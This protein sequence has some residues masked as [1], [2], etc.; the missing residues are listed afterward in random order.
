MTTTIRD[1]VSDAIGRIGVL[2]NGQ[3]MPN[4]MAQKTLRAL[5]QMMS[6]WQSRGLNYQHST[7]TLDDDWALG[8]ELEGD[9][10]ALLALRMTDDYAP[11]AAT[12]L[13]RRDARVGWSHI[14][15]VLHDTPASQTDL[16][17]SSQMR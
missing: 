13:L 10:I 9:V 12:P 16:P 4:E 2:G 7:L 14:Y 5:N 8:A 15:G 6:T 17:V 11:E 3:P 1:I